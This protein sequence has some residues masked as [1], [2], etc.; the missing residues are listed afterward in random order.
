MVEEL[1]AARICGDKSRYSGRDG[2]EVRCRWRVGLNQFRGLG[3]LVGSLSRASHFGYVH[4]MILLRSIL[5]A[6]LDSHIAVMQSIDTLVAQYFQLVEVPR[7]AIPNG[8]ELINPATQHAV[9]DRM[10][11]ACLWPLPPVNYQTRVLKMILSR[12]EESIS[13]PEEDV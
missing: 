4:V 3:L 13:D 9:Y 2:V 10:F 1:T 8:R 6:T 11:D 7:L 12:L 5:S